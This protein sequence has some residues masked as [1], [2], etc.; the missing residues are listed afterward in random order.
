MNCN[1]FIDFFL[2]DV[3]LNFGPLQPSAQPSGLSPANEDE[4]ELCFEVWAPLLKEG[5]SIC[6]RSKGQELGP[7]RVP[8]ACIE[9][10]RWRARVVLKKDVDKVQ[11]EYCVVDS[12]GSVVYVCGGAKECHL[13]SKG[14]K[15]GY[16]LVRD[17]L[18]FG[19]DFKCAGV[20]VPV[21]AL[22]TRESMGV[23]EF[24]DIIPMI[25]L[26]KRMGMQVLQLLP[27]NDSGDDPSPYSA[28]SAFALHPVHV[29]LSAVVDYYHS[30]DK[31]LS[32]D[33]EELESVA[34]KLNLSPK[35]EYAQ[36][37]A[38]KE[39]RFAELMDKVG[40]TAV[41]RDQDFD[42]F[43]S[44]NSDWLYTYATHKVLRE[45]K[46]ALQAECDDWWDSTKWPEKSGTTQRVDDNI[47]LVLLM[48]YHLHLQLQRASTYARSVGV[49]LKG[50]L[51]FGVT[52]G[53]ADVWARPSEF[54][55]R[56]KCG[57]PSLERGPAQVWG[58]P[59]YK[60]DFMHANKYR[61][62][63]R[64]L[65]RAECYFDA[66]RMDHVLGF[67]RVWSVPEYDLTGNLGW[68]RP[69]KGTTS[70]E[71]NAVIEAVDGGLKRLLEPYIDEA[72]LQQVVGPE[73]FDWASGQYFDKKQDGTYAFR[74]WTRSASGDPD[75]VKLNADAWLNGK[76]G[77]SS[78]LQEL[79]S[80]VLFVCDESLVYHPTC[81]AR[82]T[83]SFK[84]LG[85]KAREKVSA[86]WEDYYDAKQATAPK[87]GEGENLKEI[88]R[89]SR[90][91]VCG[92]DLGDIPK[93]VPPV[94]EVSL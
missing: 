25:D 49:A 24:L 88:C 39:K 3:L 15:P 1:D 8:A 12:S 85:D 32:K 94:L 55:S 40:M 67:F 86:F 93:Y 5:H 64:R 48:Q 56:E 21:P 28:I 47:K 7:E 74:D 4:F 35:V 38:E 79:A 34:E 50:D 83:H 27:T 73:D 92:E 66:V 33:R 14:D 51:P 90:L 16:V 72:Y 36:V 71:M 54:L 58:F 57:A 87:Q 69:S 9:A 41:W 65:Q 43:C 22:R 89:G 13:P 42:M 19:L 46:R 70:A 11:Y 75:Q 61:W 37:L 23:G 91:L 44:E 84:M 45:K 63:K 10:G 59:P 6:V 18:D 80:N 60:W 26:A 53:S 76:G 78:V 31:D 68:Y 62:W 17:I 29:R 81:H 77:L 52:K 30:K 82:T 20:A 2:E